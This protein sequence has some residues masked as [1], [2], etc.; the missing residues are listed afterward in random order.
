M[1]PSN[2]VELDPNLPL[3]FGYWVPTEEDIEDAGDGGL[4][5]FHDTWLLG[6]VS[7]REAREVVAEEAELIDHVDAV[8]VD[9]T[10]FDD[11]AA[12][13]QWGVLEEDEFSDL[14]ERPA[15]SAL[16]DG[17]PGEEGISSH[18]ELGV[19]GLAHAL[20]AVG[21]VP[22]ASCRGHSTSHTW[23][24]APVV[25]LATD[26]PRATI[27]QRLVAEFQCGLDHD[28]VNRPNF[29]IVT[30]S[31]ISDMNRLATA[32]LD[33]ADEFG[34]GTVIQ[35]GPRKVPT[36]IEVDPGRPE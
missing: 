5:Y 15:W 17:M 12:A 6:E 7:L 29:L 36:S 30:G 16:E 34:A 2:D 10:E 20:A 23:S 27:L 26:R 21:L 3:G 13:V 25:F 35:S 32:V 1:V 11:L 8:A 24:E 31:N 33:A 4:G 9:D 28:A 22:V 14:R 18:L 19:G